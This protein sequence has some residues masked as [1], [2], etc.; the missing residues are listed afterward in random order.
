MTRDTGRKGEAKYRRSVIEPFVTALPPLKGDQALN[1]GQAQ[2]C[3]RQEMELIEGTEKTGQH[4]GAD[5]GATVG[6]GE[7]IP[8]L[9][10]TPAQPDP[11]TRAP[12]LER[13]FQE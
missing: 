7:A 11:S 8:V 2:A 13:V 10:Q 1:D 3:G 4:R 9:L 6:D 5:A 12:V